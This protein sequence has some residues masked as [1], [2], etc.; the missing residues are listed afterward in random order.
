MAIFFVKTILPVVIGAAAGYA[1]YKFIGCVTGT[2]PI[3]ANPL[4]STLYGAGLGYL[5]SHLWK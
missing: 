1:Y 3:T 4:M 2:C 5:V